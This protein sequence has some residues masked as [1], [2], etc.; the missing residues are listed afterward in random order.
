MAF[1]THSNMQ[2]MELP[3]ELELPNNAVIGRPTKY[4]SEFV[5]KA[6]KLCLM[7]ATD[8]QLADFFDVTVS[9]VQ[10]WKLH[11]PKFSDS[12]KNAKKELDNQV[13]KSLFHRAMG[14]SHPEDKIFNDK[15]DI[16]KVNTTKQYAPDTVACIFWLKNRQPDTW[17]DR[18]QTDLTNSDGSLR[19][20][21]I[22]QVSAKLQHILDNARQLKDVK[23]KAITV[24]AESVNPIDEFI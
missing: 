3:I 23:A 8:K 17:R 21:D 13:E 18:I 20:V 1:E 6:Y 7:G 16:T 10:E 24:N 4:R 9:T 15:G 14:Y 5:I 19:N 2:N 12:I 22:D 11:H